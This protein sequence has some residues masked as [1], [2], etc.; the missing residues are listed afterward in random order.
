[1]PIFVIFDERVN[2]E[3]VDMQFSCIREEPVKLIRYIL[4]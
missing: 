1:M 2:L 4:L 3:I